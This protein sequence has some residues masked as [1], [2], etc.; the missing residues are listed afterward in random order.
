MLALWGGV[1]IAAETEALK[2]WQQWAP[3]A[4]GRAIDSGHFL[5]EEI[6]KRP[7]RH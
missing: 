2:I 6:R 4:T 7:R 5:T 3:Q 1:G